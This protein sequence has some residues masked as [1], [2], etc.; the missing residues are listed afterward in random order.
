MSIET[1][2]MII[3]ASLGYAVYITWWCPCSDPYLLSCHQPHF[4]LATG[5]PLAYIFYKNRL[6]TQGN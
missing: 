2:R 5:L 3:C 4:Y 1:D 6:E